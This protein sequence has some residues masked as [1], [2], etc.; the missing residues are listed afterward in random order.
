MSSDLLNTIRKQ[1]KENPI[2]YLVVFT[3]LGA[4]TSVAFVIPTTWLISENIR[5]TPLREE[6]V[7]AKDAL[8]IE[9]QKICITPD[10]NKELNFKKLEIERDYIN[11]KNASLSKELGDVKRNLSELSI[12]YN[13]INMEYNECLKQKDYFQSAHTELSKKNNLL[14]EKI[15]KLDPIISAEKKYKQDCEWLQSKKYE[16]YCVDKEKRLDE[17]RKAFYSK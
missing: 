6:L 13:K 15:S 17:L 7:R 12:N 4:F 16:P 9:K 2:F 3:L 10:P 1:T 14:N 5:V 11:V 8:S